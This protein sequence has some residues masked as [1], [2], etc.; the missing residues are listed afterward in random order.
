MTTKPILIVAGEPYSVFIEIYL[1]SLCKKKIKNMKDP[2]ILICSKSL[3]VKQM[4]KLKYKYKI[5][6]VSKSNLDLKKFNFQGMS[7]TPEISYIQVEGINGYVLAILESGNIK[8]EL[9][10]NNISRSTVSGTNPV[11]ASQVPVLKQYR[12]YGAFPTLVS[13]IDLSYE[14]T[15]SIEE[16][17]TEGRFENNIRK[18]NRT[19]LINIITA[20]YNAAVS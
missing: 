8:A 13:A 9:N 6:D 5:R 14:N 11:S 20:S 2:I 16:F 15:D 10:S 19:D 3:L 17:I 12:F 7:A 4:D 1:K 18:C